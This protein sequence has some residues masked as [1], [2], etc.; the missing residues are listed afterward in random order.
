MDDHNFP[1]PDNAA[2]NTRRRS[3]CRS[4]CRLIGIVF[5][6]FILVSAAATLIFR[7]GAP[8][9]EIDSI[10]VKGI[11]LTS[12]ST[13][14]PEFDVSVKVDNGNKIGIYYGYDNTVKIFYR[15][16]QL[17]KGVLPTFYHPANNVTVFNTV[18]KGNNVKLAESDQKVLADDIAKQNVLLMLKLQVDVTLKVGKMNTMAR[19]FTFEC[20]VTVDE[21]TEQAKI[22]HN[23]HC[24]VNFF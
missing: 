10:S 20:N 3:C 16:I 14:S 18:L 1:P 21:L 15:D 22:V 13:I 19:S 17:S 8:K 24:W 4:F 6:L 12:L 23:N 5:A 11:N 2:N 7:P 9:Y